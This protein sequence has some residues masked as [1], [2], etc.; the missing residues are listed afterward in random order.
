MAHCATFLAFS[1]RNN[2]FVMAMD[3][4]FVWPGFSSIGGTLS[5]DYIEDY[6]M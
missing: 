4:A 6:R 5:H 2:E 1:L 3:M